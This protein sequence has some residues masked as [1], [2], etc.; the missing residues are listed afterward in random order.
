MSLEVLAAMDL[1]LARAIEVTE[2]DSDRIGTADLAAL[3]RDALIAHGKR[4]VEV[5]ARPPWPAPEEW[6]LAGAPA[7]P[8]RTSTLLIR[9][10]I[11][12]PT[13]QPFGLTPPGHAASKRESRQQVRAVAGDPF[14]AT[15]TGF[16]DY[17]SAG[18]RE[19]TRAVLA[20]AP[21][22]SVVVV[23]P[24]GSGKTLTVTGPASLA[25]PRQSLLVVPTVALALDLERRLA[26]EHG[27]CLPFAYHGNLSPEEKVAFRARVRSGEQ[28]L[29]VT[30][31]EAACTALARPLEE[32]AA[33]GRLRY[34]A[35]DE[36]HMV[37]AW[38]E[39]FRPAFQALAGLRNRLVERGQQAGGRPPTTVLLSGT[40]DHHGL[41]V[42]SDL[43]CDGPP[44]VV[45]SQA[46][47][48][49]PS[50]WSTACSDEDEKRDRLVEAVRHLPRPTLIY[51]SL[52]SSEL[53]TTTADVERWLA[54]AG[55]RRVLRVDGTI[56]K[57][58]A[59]R[60]AVS[61]LR[62]EGNPADDV[63]IVVAT[64]AFGLGVDIDNVRTVIHACVPESVDRFYQEVGRAGRD[65]KASC[66]LLLW[67][68]ADRHVARFMA[69]TSAI[70]P[71]L[72]WERW[73]AMRR[74]MEPGGGRQRVSLTAFHAGVRHAGSEANRFW[75]VQ[76]LTT[77]AR[78]GMIKLSWPDVRMPS[79][80]AN[81]DEMA[82]AF[83][84]YR[85][86]ALVEMRHDD[87]GDLA[88]FVDRF[89]KARS[90]STG[91]AAATLSSMEDLLDDPATCVN[92][93]FAQLYKLPTPGGGWLLVD[94]N[95]GGCPACRAA[96][97]G[98]RSN[99]P[100]DLEPLDTGPPRV[101]AILTSFLAGGAACIRYQSAGSV[102]WSRLVPVV[103]RLVAHGV[104]LLVTPPG[105][106]PRLAS[107]ALAASPE[108]WVCRESLVRWLASPVQATM[109]TVV[110]IE[111]HTS[112]AMAGD[113]LAALAG[114]LAVILVV[115]EDLADPRDPRR[116]F[117]ET[118]RPSYSLDSVLRRL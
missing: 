11:W 106:P 13:W 105:T 58:D 100:P 18:Q 34:F 12:F 32:A 73:Q 74:G 51:T 23:L 77:M 36:A 57:T 117:Y 10:R 90:A 91:H 15:A 72:G 8:G 45:S 95:C 29:V 17:R 82:A 107:S 102:P 104:R 60:H 27:A 14:L 52:H 35:I 50:Y 25:R 49:E 38:G 101:S 5:P 7:T 92:R 89:A 70:G 65:G 55:V 103:D 40:L 94:E 111:P 33:A 39:D 115:P 75:N 42:L 98:P 93:R 6:T 3:V 24:T 16:S 85:T 46:T 118:I 99:V 43:F 53:S 84:E 86:S 59:R 47:R 97:R 56:K 76:T 54:E 21:G 37:A 113:V 78:A 67:T 44:V 19:A 66:S 88:T 96:G 9:P 28:W 68:P 62:C 87:L 20:T 26:A 108:R 80:D 116:R 69:R 4:E 31:P 63:D 22:R 1:R 112:P 71:R 2:R 109:A 110:V 79:E 48:P 61:A 64:S 30:S 41:A 81:D 83:E 114:Q